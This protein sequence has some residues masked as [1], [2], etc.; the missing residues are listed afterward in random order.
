MPG[1]YISDLKNQTE[2]ELSI[3]RQ[4]VKDELCCDDYRI[5]R[6]TLPKYLNDKC[7]V[8]NDRFVIVSEGVILNKAALFSEYDAESVDEIGR[9]S[10]RERVFR[11]V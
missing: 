6:C 1:F 2:P 7:F 4:S 8:S 9:A 5:K 10:C 11:A 3:C